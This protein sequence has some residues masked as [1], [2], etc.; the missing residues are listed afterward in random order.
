MKTFE[1]A[2]QIVLDTSFRKGSERVPFMK[3]IGRILAE[4]ITSD[5]MMPPFDKSAVDGYACRKADLGNDLELIEVV[6]AGKMPVKTLQAGQCIKVMTGAPV[7]QGADMVIRVE[8]VTTPDVNRISSPAGQKKNNICLTGEDIKTGE[9]VLTSGT[10]V[11][12]QHIAV[13]AAVGAVHPLVYKKVMVAVI[14]SGDELVEPDKTPPLS[15][16]RNGNAYQLCA[17]IEKCGAQPDYVG[18][19]ADTEESTRKMI[20]RALDGNDMVLISGGVSMGDFDFVPQVFRELGIEVLFEKVAV[21]PG[22]PTVFGKRNRQFVFGLPGNPVSAFVQFELLVKPL[23]HKIGGNSLKPLMVSLPMR[24]N[25][26]RR[27]ADRMSFIPVAIN[28]Q[29]EVIPLDYHGSAHINSLV[30]AQGFVSLAIG[31]KTLNKGEFVN[32]RFI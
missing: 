9:I 15:K 26:Q 27:K 30:E 12:P 7:P 24:N 14:S 21:Q 1:E 11:E 4:D 5:L 29:S 6:P 22:K 18:I 13:M 31:N 25:Y 8:D 28:D 32:V 16:I 2:L 23:I 19:A 10:L 3:S 17:Q 20:L